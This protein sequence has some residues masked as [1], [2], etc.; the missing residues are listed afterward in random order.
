MKIML[1]KTL[2]SLLIGASLLLPIYAKEDE[3]TKTPII[4]PP[5]LLQ[6]VDETFTW[7]NPR[8]EIEFLQSQ[9]VEKIFKLRDMRLKN[10]DLHN[11]E[12]L[13]TG[14]IDHWGY[15]I[16]K[17]IPLEILSEIP[18][19]SIFRPCISN[20]YDGFI[21]GRYP[22]YFLSRFS[23]DL[24]S[25]SIKTAEEDPNFEKGPEWTKKEIKR[26][27]GER[28]HVYGNPHNKLEYEL[29]YID[30][31]E[32]PHIATTI[33]AYI[34]FFTQQETINQV[35]QMINAD[36]PKEEKGGVILF[37][38]KWR[39][40]PIAQK[41]PDAQRFGTE[42]R[43]YDSPGLLLFTKTTGLLHVH[44]YDRNGVY[45]EPSQTDLFCFTETVS[46]YNP[47]YVHVLYSDLGFG[48]Y[49]IDFFWRDVHTENGK[50]ISNF[51]THS[52]DIGNVT[53]SLPASKLYQET[54]KTKE[55]GE[56]QEK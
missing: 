42:E 16:E 29:N 50:H 46:E 41:L 25:Y 14:F 12:K 36:H 21:E 38:K 8:E 24:P 17:G 20:M 28:E 34:D 52:I 55:P 49:N 45:A 10:P 3:T 19:S 37:D 9:T 22:E 13:S 40:F 39:F 48:K 53:S 30:L 56:T 47:F 27:V 43:S 7:G 32:S 35:H 2:A 33:N 11:C 6:K 23:L 15:F 51:A 44:T 18:E 1:K 26:K 54:Y 4:H 31:L 5:A